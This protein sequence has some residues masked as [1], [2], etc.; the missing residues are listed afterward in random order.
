MTTPTKTLAFFGATGG[1]ANYCLIHA[2]NAGYKST[3]LVRNSSKLTD[4]LKSRN[5]SDETIAKYLTIIQG[6]ATDPV[7]VRKTL[8]P[9]GGSRVVDIIINGVGGAPVFQW[10]FTKPFVLD[11]PTI[12]QDVGATILQVSRDLAT[13][14]SD[15]T[16]PLFINISTT[17]I[18]P[19]G[20]PWDVPFW[21]TWL[22]HYALQDPHADKKRLQELNAAEVQS[23]GCGIEGYVNVKASLLMDGEGIGLEK[24]RVGTEE[25]PAIGYTIQRGD[26]GRFVFERLV[27]EDVKGDW[28]NMSLTITY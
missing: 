16:K 26:V 19:E 24:V 11:Q 9:N 3:A 27:R 17:G 2:L 18:P 23:E 10:S 1:C 8:C 4:L 6:N 12:C 28:R 25:E 5:V 7:A 13:S 20:R 22:Y 15:A 14:S 21:F